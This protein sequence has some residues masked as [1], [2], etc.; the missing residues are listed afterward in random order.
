MPN[1][2]I[3][4]TGP[5][6]ETATSA[7]PAA[8]LTAVGAPPAFGAFAPR[9]RTLMMRPHLRSRMPGMTKRLSRIAENN[10]RSRSSCQTS[11]LTSR[12]A[13]RCDVPALFTKTSIL[14][15][16]A[17]MLGC[18]VCICSSSV[19][20]VY[21]SQ[22]KNWRRRKRRRPFLL[23]IAHTHKKKI[24]LHQCVTVC[25]SRLLLYTLQSVGKYHFLGGNF[26]TLFVSTFRG[27]FV[28]FFLVLLVLRKQQKLLCQIYLDDINKGRMA[29]LIAQK[30]LLL[31]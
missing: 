5:D 19:E 7:M 2:S 18:F 15:N 23:Q 4:V 14:P 9:F 11:S 17:I 26:F 1:R 31:E 21:S 29:K 20:I 25:V 3:L 12:N 27:D 6:G 8:R 24:P 22:G 30:R 10:F 13:P 16:S 28:S